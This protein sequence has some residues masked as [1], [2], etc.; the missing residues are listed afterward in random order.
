MHCEDCKNNQGCIESCSD[1]T[2]A[3]C[4]HR[5]EFEECCLSML[6]DLY[7]SKDE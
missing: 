2:C 7:E 4:I 6:T 1:C 3:S 5:Y